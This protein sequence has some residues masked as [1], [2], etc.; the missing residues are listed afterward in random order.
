MITEV[1]PMLFAQVVG[2]VAFVVAVVI[3]VVFAIFLYYGKFWFQAYMSGVPLSLWDIIGM[4]LRKADPQAVVISLVMAKQVADVTIS[5]S[6]AEVERAS[7]LGVDVVKITGAL[8]GLNRAKR[9]VASSID[10]LRP[11]VSDEAEQRRQ[12]LLQDIEKDNRE[13][14]FQ[15]LVDA[16]LRRMAAKAIAK[17]GGEVK[18]ASEGK[19]PPGPAA[20][21]ERLG[22]HFFDSIV[23]LNLDNTE[24]ANIDLTLVER[25]TD[26]ERLSLA[27]TDIDDDGLRHFKGLTKL[28]QLNLAKTKVTYTGISDLSRALPECEILR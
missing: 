28:R 27:G 11:A 13:Y 5:I 18:Y 20:L 23:G 21:R 2:F 26:L 9:S 6:P 7:I 24:I 22:E 15:E 4:S 16:D 19:E 17:S 10:L 8:I 12:E 25:L 1:F 14:T 3:L